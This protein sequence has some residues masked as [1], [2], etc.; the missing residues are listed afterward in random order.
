VHHG[1]T[2]LAATSGI[3][4]ASAIFGFDHIHHA[5][6]HSLTKATIEVLL[7]IHQL[8]FEE[9]EFALQFLNHLSLL[10]DEEFELSDEMQILRTR[11]ALIEA[12]LRLIVPAN[13]TK[14]AKAKLFDL[15]FGQQINH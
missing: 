5:D 7:A 9:F 12:L 14:S 3:A 8:E 1:W 15:Q 2:A 11:L 13:N 4:Q 6:I 10:S